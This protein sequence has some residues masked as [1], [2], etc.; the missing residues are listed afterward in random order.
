MR[1][2]MITGPGKVEVREVAEP[3]CGPRDVKV[4]M[5]ASG[6]C[7]SDHMYIAKG[8]L[9]NNPGR[10]PL[11]HEAAGEIVEVGSEVSDFRVGDHVVLDP[12]AFLDGSFGSGGDQGGLNEY[13]VVHEAAP[14]KQLRVIPAEIPWEVAALNEPMAVSRHAVN[15]LEM[16]AGAK[17]CIFG[18]GPIGLGALLSAKVVGAGH[19][20]VVDVQ[21]AR[22][23]TALKI[24]ADAVINPTET[25]VR[26]RLIELHGEGTRGMLRDPRPDTYGFIDAAGSPAGLHTILGCLKYGAVV[27]IPAVYKE[28]VEI[29]LLGLLPAEPDI[30][31]SMAYP[32]EIFEV[33]DDI[34]AQADKY[35]QIISHVMPYSEVLDAIELSGTP[36]ATDKVVVLLDD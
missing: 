34:I 32:T 27:S 35:R 30:R 9:G 11:G 31:M 25:D 12:M 5:K 16:P 4:K 13:V 21:P 28:K 22:L 24:G 18:A 29:D 36:G 10:H 19:V 6:I 23:E 26:E 3:S 14:G 17:I 15:R 1:S 33:T 7:G 8:G 20:V 2:V